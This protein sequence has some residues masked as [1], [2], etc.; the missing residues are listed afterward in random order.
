MDV[1]N[2]INDN[3]KQ[4]LYFASIL[5][6]CAAL[7]VRGQSWKLDTVNI[8]SQYLTELHSRLSANI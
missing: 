7:Q 5:L 6:S 3:V 8:V 4:K 1:T 2:Q